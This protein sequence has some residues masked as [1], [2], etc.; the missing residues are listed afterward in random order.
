[1]RI[2]P[3]LIFLLVTVASCG[4]GKDSAPVPRRYA[5]PRPDI[6]PA[7]YT[8]LDF[9][10]YRLDI[11]CSAAVVLDSVAGNRRDI[12]LAYPGFGAK[13]YLTVSNAPDSATLAAMAADRTARFV[14]NVAG[15]YTAEEC[16]SAESLL[17]T[18]YQGNVTPLQFVV[19]SEL[20]ML[21]GVVY[22]TDP[23]VAAR[24]DS[25]RPVFEALRRDIVRLIQSF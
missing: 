22:F 7:G 23:D 11:S 4:G 9:G 3:I 14:R 17:I 2:L 16:D 25:M 13:V 24:P 21:S 12:T 19:L 20:S 15:R 1:M 8:V 18:A 10:R 5:Y 6:P